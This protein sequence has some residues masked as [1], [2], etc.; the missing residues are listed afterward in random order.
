MA[1]KDGDIVSLIEN[2]LSLEKE[3]DHI[4]E[5]AQARS[6]K[7][8][9]SADDEFSAFRDRET[10]KLEERIAAFREQHEKEYNNFVSQVTIEHSKKLDAIR[11]LSEEFINQQVN[12]II[13]RFNNW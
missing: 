6:K 1:K 9:K 10:K 2:I 12:K 3:A 13:D 7:L 4:I 8:L 5:E 11:Q